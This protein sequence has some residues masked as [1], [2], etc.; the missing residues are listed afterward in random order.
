METKRLKLFVRLTFVLLNLSCIAG[1]IE[2]YAK[3]FPIFHTK[4]FNVF[5]LNI[6]RFNDIIVAVPVW[7]VMLLIVT[8][9]ICLVCTR[10]LYKSVCSKIV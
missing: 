8:I 9:F 4:L 6:L 3:I 10:L 2:L 7:P 5:D 1:I